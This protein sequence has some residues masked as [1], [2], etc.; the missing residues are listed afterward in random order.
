MKRLRDI[1]EAKDHLPLY[2]GEPVENEGP[3]EHSHP[4]GVFF[5]DA[6]GKKNSEGYT[7]AVHD[8]SMKGRVRKYNLPMDHYKKLAHLHHDKTYHKLLPHP[9]DRS[10]DSTRGVMPDKKLV[11]ALHKHGHTG[12]KWKSPDGG[13]SQY[14][15]LSKHLEGRKYDD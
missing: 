3:K 4:G 10:S 8:G 13:P 15:V 12:Y 6:S 14:F 9:D 1:V 2:R 5:H 7:R 11:D